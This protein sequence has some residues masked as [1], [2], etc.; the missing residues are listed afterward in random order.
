MTTDVL[1]IGL[2]ALVVVLLL[3]VMGLVLM[4]F[5]RD[6]KPDQDRIVEHMDQRFKQISTEVLE[7]QQGK[8]KE[9]LDSIIT[10]YKEGLEKAQEKLDKNL[11]ETAEK[12]AAIQTH[13]NQMSSTI[14]DLGE[15]TDSLSKALRGEKVKAVGDWGEMRL[16]RVLEVAGMQKGENFLTQQ[17]YTTPEG[18]RL[19][20]DFV[21]TLPDNKAIVVDAKVALADYLKYIEAEDE[22]ARKQSLADLIQ[23][24]NTQVEQA[25]KYHD[26]KLDGYEMLDVVLM[27]MPVEGAWD[28]L[29]RNNDKEKVFDKAFAKKVLMVGQVNLLSTLST[30]MHI[31]RGHK[32]EKST[33]EIM[34]LTAQLV[35]ALELTQERFE[36]L[37]EQNNKGIDGLR[38]ALEGKQGALPYA[39][40][41][42]DLGAKGKKD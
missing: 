15:E 10:P 27:F 36:K 39:K 31:W 34:G 21:L 38:K 20:P 6:N 11:V 9:S 8:A 3:A 37:E 40:R 5:F 4:L 33:E 22:G 26:F 23:A 2:I 42:R 1:L 16:E 13:F 41:L 12:N 29:L 17:S 32:L 18:K 19:Q 7:H 14:K 24:V 30:I 25:C 28:L 35:S